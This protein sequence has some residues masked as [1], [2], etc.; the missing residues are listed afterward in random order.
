MKIE[1]IK[2]TDLAG[3]SMYFVTIDNK[4]VS[5]SMVANEEKAFEMYEFALANRGEKKVE[6]IKQTEI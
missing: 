6:I 1:L 3:H 4:Y 5:G 2:E